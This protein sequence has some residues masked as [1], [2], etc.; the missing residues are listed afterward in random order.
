MNGVCALNPCGSLMHQ[1]IILR[2]MLL[3]LV[4]YTDDIFVT[5]IVQEYWSVFE[6]NGV[7]LEKL[8][9]WKL[10]SCLENVTDGHYFDCE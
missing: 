6:N 9:S 7:F 2:F 8:G 10:N 1:V 5:G 3:S 4:S